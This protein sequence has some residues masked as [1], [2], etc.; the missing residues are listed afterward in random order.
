MK[1]SAA[2]TSETSMVWPKSGC[3]ISGTMVS[4]SSR[5]ARTLPASAG[6]PARPPSEKAQAARMTK[7]GLMN[8]DG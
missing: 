7:A 2:Q 3:R 1:N 4:G 5:K 8:S 6:A